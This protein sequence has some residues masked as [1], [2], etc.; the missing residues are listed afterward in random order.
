MGLNFTAIIH[1][2]LTNNTLLYKIVYPSVKIE[3]VIPMLVKLL[4]NKRGIM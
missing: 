2:F 4:K 3:L 1:I